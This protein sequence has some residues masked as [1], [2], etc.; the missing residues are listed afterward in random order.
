MPIYEFFCGPCNTVYKFFSRT[1]NT[2]KIPH[3]PKCG[4]PELERRVSLFA[5]IGKYSDESAE[6]D[7]LPPMDESRMEKTMAAL[8]REAGKIN[9]E[10]PKAAAEL[11]RKFSEASGLKLGPGMEEAM[12]RLEKGEDPEQ[13]E[14]EMGD[15]LESE[16]PF[17]LENNSKKSG[18]KNKPR[19]DDQL[20][21]L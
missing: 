16:E 4:N 12:R 15:L 13:I 21:D 2:E 20:Y 11:M 8:A 6:E 3:C 14:A 19:Y 7:N 18:K 1:V 10:D 5:I 17:L 9:E